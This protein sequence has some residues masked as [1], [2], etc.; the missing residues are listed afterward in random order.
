VRRIEN[1]VRSNM[2]SPQRRVITPTGD[3]TSNVSPV[4]EPAI[5]SAESVNP[6]SD[7]SQRYE[8]LSTDVG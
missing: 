3:T 5:A 4:S 8:F 1:L 6:V 2:P 7:N